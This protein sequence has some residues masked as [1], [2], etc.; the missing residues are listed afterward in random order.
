MRNLSEHDLIQIWEIGLRQHPID[1]ALTILAAAAPDLGWDELETLSIGQRDA[2]LLE[3][4]HRTF[5]PDLESYAECPQC[6]E[7]LEFTL[8]AAQLSASAPPATAEATYQWSGDDFTIEFRLPNSRDLAA[9]VSCGQPE[10]AHHLLVSR[11]IVGAFQGDER[12]VPA[13]LP[14]AILGGIAERMTKHDPL[15]E[16]LLD[17]TCPACQSRWQALFDIGAFL[18]SEL[19]ATARRLLREIHTLARAYGWREADILAL[20]ATRR[21]SY[22]ELVS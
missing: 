19:A 16:V 7:R 18:W 17:L 3:V 20:S 10:R 2:R 6:A 22:L 4:W 9:I 1:R 8:N 5:G 15:A 14:A 12:I 13:E 11:C 21:Q